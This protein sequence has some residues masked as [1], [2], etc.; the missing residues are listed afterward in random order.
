M[1]HEP[2]PPC[3]GRH[4]AERRDVLRGALSPDLIFS[5]SRNL[6]A[7]G[8][9]DKKRE[10]VSVKWAVG[11]LTAPWALTHPFPPYI[12]LGER[13]GPQVWVVH[14]R[15]WGTWYTGYVFILRFDNNRRH[16]VSHPCLPSALSE[17]LSWVHRLFSASLVFGVSSRHI[18]LL[19]AGLILCCAPDLSL[20]CAQWSTCWVPPA[21]LAWDPGLSWNTGL[22]VLKLAQSQANQAGWSPY[23]WNS[24]S[25]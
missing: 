2:P 11:R 17:P 13:V 10:L 18:I 5:V 25:H 20:L 12:D 4:G 14:L 15:D 24:S 23:V 22:V 16:P 7:H 3:L 21:H 6:R 19:A 1:A 8:L 9:H